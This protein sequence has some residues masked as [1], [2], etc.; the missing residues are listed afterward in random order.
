MANSDWDTN[1]DSDSRPD[2]YIV[3]YRNF[4]PARS[5][6]QIPIQIA[7]YRKGYEPESGSK[8]VFGNVIKPLLESTSQYHTVLKQ[9]IAT[10]SSYFILTNIGCLF[11]SATRSRRVCEDFTRDLNCP[12]EFIFHY[13]RNITEESRLAH[14][15][16]VL[17][18]S[19]KNLG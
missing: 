14:T 13:L 15:K 4:H 3:L 12:S 9:K 18:V 6:I 7:S 19:F 5:H 1:S 16:F 2:S 17:E 11:L 8:S 10:F